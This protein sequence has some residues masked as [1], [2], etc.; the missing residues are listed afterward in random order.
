MVLSFRSICTCLS[1]FS[2]P[3]LFISTTIAFRKSSSLGFKIS[4]YLFPSAVPSVSPRSSSATLFIVVT[5]PDLSMETTPAATLLRTISIYRLLCSS[6]SFVLLRSRFASSILPFVALKS[7]V[8]LLNE[9]T[10]T[11]ISSFASISIW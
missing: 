2:V 5:L 7:P 6:S 8:I 10:R 4:L 3:L 1:I 11:P 9:F